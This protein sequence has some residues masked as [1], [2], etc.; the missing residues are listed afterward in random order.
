MAE[1]V[2]GV[3]Y[4]F[5]GALLWRIVVLPTEEFDPKEFSNLTDA[6]RE[7]DEWRRQALIE[8]GEGQLAILIPKATFL[9]FWPLAL[10]AG[11]LCARL[12][13]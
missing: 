1:L 7:Q 12:S 10:G 5:I 3:T 8:E 9:F 2:L 4:A 11:F 6:Q 13:K